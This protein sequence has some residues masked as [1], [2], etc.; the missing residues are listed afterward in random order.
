[1]VRESLTTLGRHQRD[2]RALLAASLGLLGC[3][4]PPPPPSPATPLRS[5]TCLG[6]TD[7][8]SFAVYLHGVDEAGISDQELENRRTLDAVAREL[9]M[10]I[11][12]PRASKPCPT[13]PGELCWG[14]TFDEPELDAA[15][16]AVKDAAASCFGAPRPFGLIGFSNGGYLVTKLLRTCSL[17]QRLPRASWMMTVGSAMN[18][19]PLEGSPADLS[20]CGRLVM[21]VG[22]RDTYNFDPHEELLHG[23]EAKHADVHSVRFDGG[24]GVPLEATR[25]AV[26]ALLRLP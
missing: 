23:L 18:H 2:A 11:A 5:A 12:L 7:A 16:T 9:S 22:T 21:L 6:P 13:Q 19:G 24:H 4:R 1:M 8:T 26:A 20:A 17:H 15:A 3:S 25:E 10:R 14:W